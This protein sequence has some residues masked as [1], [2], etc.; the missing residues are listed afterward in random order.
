MSLKSAMQKH[1]SHKNIY[2]TKSTMEPYLLHKQAL[3]TLHSV[4]FSSLPTH[5]HNNAHNHTGKPHSD[6]VGVLI[7]DIVTISYDLIMTK[8]H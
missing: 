5:T 4:P 7:P 1:Y 8:L 6:L 3:T 2:R